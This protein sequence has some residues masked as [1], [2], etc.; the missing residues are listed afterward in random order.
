MKEK[1]E[2]KIKV[3]VLESVGV[4]LCITTYKEGWEGRKLEREDERGREQEIISGD[5]YIF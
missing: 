1:Y 2:D 4:Q 3:R 5:I